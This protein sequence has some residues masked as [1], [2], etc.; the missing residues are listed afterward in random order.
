MATIDP[1]IAVDL[2]F[3]M[4]LLLARWVGDERFAP[5]RAWFY[6]HRLRGG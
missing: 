1:A 6:A 2:C 5:C 3:L 4:V